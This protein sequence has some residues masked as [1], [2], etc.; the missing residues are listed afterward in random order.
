MDHNKTGLVSYDPSTPADDI[1]GANA[2]C[3]LA[4]DNANGP[5]FVSQELSKQS[6]THHILIGTN[7]V[8]SIEDVAVCLNAPCGA[9]ACE[10]VDGFELARST[11]F[12]CKSVLD[13][14]MANPDCTSPSKCQ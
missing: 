9:A 10:A 7:S 14:L 13:C 1:F 4:P 5:Y 6:H 12:P 8:P 3:I 11:F 2:S